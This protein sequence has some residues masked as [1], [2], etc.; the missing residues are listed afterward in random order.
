MHIKNTFRVVT[1]SGM[2][3]TNTVLIAFKSVYAALKVMHYFPRNGTL[4]TSCFTIRYFLWDVFSRV[5]LPTPCFA[6]GKNLDTYIRTN[7][8][9]PIFIPLVR[10]KSHSDI[11]SAGTSD[12]GYRL[13]V[14][15][16]HKSCNLDLFKFR[17]KRYLCCITP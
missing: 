15:Y 10:R 5:T 16:F 14:G 17:V 11:I 9:H 12:L 7:H 4:R 3:L 8:P 2:Q 6:I 13:Y 1:I